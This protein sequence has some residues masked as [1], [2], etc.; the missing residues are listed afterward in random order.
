[1]CCCN[2][3]CAVIFAGFYTLV[4]SVAWAILAFL[5]ISLYNCDIEVDDSNPVYYLYFIYFYN[6]GCATLPDHLNITKLICDALD[7]ENVDC[8]A[9]TDYTLPPEWDG[10]L[11]PGLTMPPGMTLPPHFPSFPPELAGSTL[12]PFP[13]WPDEFTLAK[14]TNLIMITVMGLVKM[15]GVQGVDELLSYLDFD[16]ESLL[17]NATEY[18]K[19]PASIMAVLASRA[20][21]LWV[22]NVI[23]FICVFFASRSLCKNKYPELP[24]YPNHTR[25]T[26]VNSGHENQAYQPERK[27]EPPPSYQAF[28]PE[29]KPDPASAF[30]V[31]DDDGYLIG[32]QP[33][34][35]SY[36]NGVVPPLSSFGPR[37]PDD[38][39]RFGLHKSVAPH[40]EPQET[41]H[42]KQRDI[43]HHEAAHRQHEIPRPAM[44]KPVREPQYQDTAPAPWFQHSQ[45]EARRRKDTPMESAMPGMQR[46][47][48]Y[49]EVKPVG[50]TPSFQEHRNSGSVMPP[51]E[52]RSQLPWSY[53]GPRDA[54]MK[55]KLKSTAAAAV[56]EEEEDMPPVPVPDYT[57]HFGKTS[58][59]RAS[60][61]SDQAYFFKYVSTKINSLSNNRETNIIKDNK[62]HNRHMWSLIPGY[63]PYYCPLKKLMET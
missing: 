22:L 7:G 60:D 24:R 3:R 13:D 39:P 43:E 14:D 45:Q 19:I 5:A 16:Y 62:R 35:F 8:E 34:P 9:L 41:S 6:T 52:L 1:M 25:N 30:N 57:L 61:W 28:Q 11:P 20:I 49:E 38:P 50:R 47:N 58:R 26:V 27:S 33:R 40:R 10:T 37:N 12:P 31:Y 56:K 55:P 2:S 4:Q 17:K 48:S 18:S 51:D 54:P 46:P 36:T 21:V 23:V 53:F 29:K 42:V 15:I 32:P 63:K 59:P 44:A